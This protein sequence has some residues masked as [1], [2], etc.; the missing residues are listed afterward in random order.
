MV[1]VCW[2]LDSGLGNTLEGALIVVL[3]LGLVR[4]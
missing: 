1:Q 2:I 4:A 3:F